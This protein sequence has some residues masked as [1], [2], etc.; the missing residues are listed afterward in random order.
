MLSPTAVSAA[1][2]RPP[3]PILAKL[4]RFL[5]AMSL[6]L[7]PIILAL[8]ALGGACGRAEA[9]VSPAAQKVLQRAFAASGGAGWY[10]IRGWRETGRRDGQTYESWIDPVRYGLRVETRGPK[11][12]SIEGFNGQAV[13]R[14]RP[15]GA[16]EAVNDHATLAQARTE[17]FFAAS[18][19][20]FPGRF[21]ARGDYVGVRS[22]QG[23]SYEV[24]RVQ[25]WGGLPRELWFDAQ[26]RLL[27]RIVDRSGKTGAV[28]L[29]DYHRIGPVLIPFRLTPEGGAEGPLVRQR[30]S[31]VFAPAERELFSLDR[32]AALAKVQHEAPA[33]R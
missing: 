30:E 22:L 15:D 8:L 29:A 13:W 19:W 2:F 27:G 11:G 32:P 26:T 6:R 17:A 31:L 12:L 28:R 3:R 25:P 14:V 21:D 16:I 7:L 5:P 18:C 9:Q 20:M 4:R 23:R 24:V 10:M 33:S 1:A